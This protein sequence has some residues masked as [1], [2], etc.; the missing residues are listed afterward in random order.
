[1]NM[2]EVLKKDVTSLEEQIAEARAAALQAET[3][4]R[5]AEFAAESIYAEMGFWDRYFFGAFG[6]KAVISA[7]NGQRSLQEKFNA[8]AQQFNNAAN[9]L[10]DS[11]DSKIGEYLLGADKNYKELVA[12]QSVSEAMKSEVDNFRAVVDEAISSVTSA[13]GMETMD[14][15]SKSTAIS[16]MSTGSNAVASGDI[17]EVREALPAFQK[18]VQKY[19]AGMNSVKGV[20]LDTDIQ[21][22]LDLAFDL[23]MDGFDF[24]SAFTL[25]KLNDAQ[26]EL[27]ELSEKVQS[28]DDNVQANLD[29][30]GKAMKSYVGEV[31][32]M[33]AR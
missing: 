30:A 23:A 12:A 19:N 2:S 25:S 1:M 18:A 27:E 33:C 5:T 28:I 16:L 29:R 31:R 7:R 17:E 13:Q 22:G 21:D 10:N 6:N 14:L 4:S 8:E 32:R 3:Q 24:M 15:V 20:Q 26:E 9:V 11:I